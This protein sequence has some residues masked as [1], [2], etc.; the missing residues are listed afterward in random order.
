MEPLID[1]MWVVICSF[2][3]PLDFVRFAGVSKYAMK[4]SM[5]ERAWYDRY[6]DLVTYNR[7]I[8]GCRDKV[9]T[10]E[11]MN[12]IGRGMRCYM[13]KKLKR[14]AFFLRAFRPIP[15]NPHLDFLSVFIPSNTNVCTDDCVNWWCLKG[16]TYPEMWGKGSRIARDLEELFDR[17]D[18]DETFAQCYNRGTLV[19]LEHVGV[20][21]LDMF[22][23]W[24]GEYRFTKIYMAS[25]S[26]PVCDGFFYCIWRCLRFGWRVDFPRSQLTSRMEEMHAYITRC[27]ASKEYAQ[28]KGNE[29]EEIDEGKQQSVRN[30][31]RLLNEFM[32]VPSETGRRSKVQ[33]RENVDS[34]HETR[35]EDELEGGGL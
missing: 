21:Y 29:K 11:Y 4:L 14:V 1:Q 3:N 18:T 17:P 27:Q 2:M 31:K 9:S 20:P 12:I 6:V 30:L 28:F 23:S 22:E 16:E 7:K 8:T 10:F 35:D 32:G 26:Y 5:N 19:A 24:D 15:E 33:R 34:E 13:I 25:S